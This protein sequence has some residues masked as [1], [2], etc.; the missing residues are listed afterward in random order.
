MNLQEGIL[1]HGQARIDRMLDFN[2]VLSRDGAPVGRGEWIADVLRTE[3]AS[4]KFRGLQVH[5]AGP[6][7]V[8]IFEIDQRATVGGHEAS[9]RWAVVDVWQ[10]REGGWRLTARHAMRIG[11]L[12]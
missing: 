3:W 1:R 9:G 4:F 11:D 8:A 2:F 10:P 5:P 12:A 6:A 7:A